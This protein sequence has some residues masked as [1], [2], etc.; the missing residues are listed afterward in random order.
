VSSEYVDEATAIA[1]K[2]TYTTA[3]DTFVL[4]AD[5]TT[6]LNP[7]GPGRQSVRLKTTKAYS[8]HVVI[9]DV[10]HM[11]QGCSTWPAAWESDTSDWPNSGEVSL[12]FF[13][14]RFTIG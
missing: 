3:Y 8:T 1:N 6:V 11:P 10:Y 12:S 4:R 5:S 14:F 13:F 7:S 2:L 9:F